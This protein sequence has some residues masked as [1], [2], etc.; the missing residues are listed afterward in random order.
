MPGPLH[1]SADVDLAA[2]EIDVTD[3]QCGGLTEPQP[4]ERAQRDERR[5]RRVRRRQQST[6]LAGD[7]IVMALAALRS[8]GNLT[9]AVTSCASTRSRTAAR[10]TLR[11]FWNR[12]LMVPGASGLSCMAFT[13]ASTCDG[14][15]S[16]NGTHANVTEPA[17]RSI[18]CR[19]VATQTWRAAHSV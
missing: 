12:V 17:A 14:R 4:S 15:R 3:S 1:L 7:G 13:H 18:A 6:H 9:A 19:V 8:R 16:A 10:M 2:Q 11:T 5:E